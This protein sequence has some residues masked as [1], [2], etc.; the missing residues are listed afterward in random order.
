MAFPLTSLK[1]IDMRLTLV[2]IPVLLCLSCSCEKEQDIKKNGRPEIN[3]LIAYVADNTGADELFLSC[4]DRTVNVSSTWKIYNPGHP[5]LS[6][7]GKSIVF[8]GNSSDGWDLYRY[9]VESG[10]LPVNLTSSVE[11]DC[12]EPSFSA[13]GSRIV[14]T[15]SGQIAM[16]N[17]D[18]ESV[19]NLTFDASAS[20]GSPAFSP[21]RNEVVY[22]DRSSGSGR[23][24]MLD[25]SDMS[26]SEISGL[27]NGSFSHPAFTSTGLLVYESAKGICSEGSVIFPDGASPSA[28][29]DDWIIFMQGGKAKIGNVTTKESYDFLDGTC[30]EVAYSSSVVS[31]A[32]PQDGGRTIGGDNI[33]SDK[34]LPALKGKIVF[35]NYSSYDA[36]DSKMYIYDFSTNTLEEISKGWGD[37]IN[38]MNGHFSPDGRYITFMGIGTETGSWDIFLYEIGSSSQPVNLTPSGTYRDEDPKFSFDGNKICFKR[39]NHLAE[40][41]VSTKAINVLSQDNAEPYSMPYYTLDGTKLVF[42]GGED[43]NSYI[44]LWD[45]FSSSA[46]K[47]YDKAGTVEYYPIVIDDKSF[48]YTQHISPTDNHDQLYKGYF[49]GSAAVPLAFNTPDADYSDACPVSQGWLILVSTCSG[50]RGGYDMYIA[51]ET[52][53]AIY[54]L[55][56]YNTAL[57]SGLNELGPDYLPPK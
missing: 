26:S 56:R 49:D 47:I 57:N 29:F 40:I 30:S 39:D 5:T 14:F 21:D 31:I 20:N 8:S 10:Q 43:P 19:R 54:S 15:K 28:A 1:S 50:G 22:V 34:D 4:N 16:M 38:M 33:S 45:I 53:G 36:R 11:G 25:I 52:S 27:G 32:N 23:L 35:H 41:N 6:P 51:N 9:D 42:S 2:V 48:Y 17:L 46:R 18:E 37:V 55:S 44:G 3:G 13:D 24:I 7:D 12:K